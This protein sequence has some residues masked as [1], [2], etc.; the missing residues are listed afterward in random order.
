MLE[1]EKGYCSHIARL[2]QQKRSYKIFG[3]IL[4]KSDGRDDDGR[5]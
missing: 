4:G 2:T 5:N 1:D 3:K